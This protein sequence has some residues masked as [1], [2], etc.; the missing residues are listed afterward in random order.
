MRRERIVVIAATVVFVLA[1]GVRAEPGRW[2][3]ARDCRLEGATV[4]FFGDATA[5]IYGS[6]RFTTDVSGGGELTR[7]L[8]WTDTWLKRGGIWQIIAAQDMW[9]DCK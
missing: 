9:A 8:V 3:D 5:V 2:A 4:H 7:C 1:S 6:E